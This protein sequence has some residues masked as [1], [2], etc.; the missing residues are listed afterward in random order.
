MNVT[1]VNLHCLKS[2]M[3]SVQ[4]PCLKVAVELGRV[5]DSHL[6]YQE[7]KDCFVVCQGLAQQ[8]GH[9]GHTAST[10]VWSRAEWVGVF[11]IG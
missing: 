1:A 4:D 8:Q 7:G 9:D 5:S 6:L 11:Y 2:A 10:R 3:D